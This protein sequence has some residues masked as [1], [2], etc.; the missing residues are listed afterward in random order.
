MKI[1]PLL[2]VFFVVAACAPTKSQSTAEQSPHAKSK[3]EASAVTQEH[4]PVPNK[5]VQPKVPASGTAAMHS[6]ASGAAN[7]PPAKIQTVVVKPTITETHSSKAKSNFDMVPV[8]AP[9]GEV[10]SR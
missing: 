1:N 2:P 5:T 6:A 10:K 8:A 3:L 7:K 9:D 4:G